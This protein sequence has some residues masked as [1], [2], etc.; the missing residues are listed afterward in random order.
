MEKKR[1]R[2]RIKGFLTQ[3]IEYFQHNST[4]FNIISTEGGFNLNYLKEH[5]YFY[6]FFP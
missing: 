1:P 4:Y 5:I 3:K 2:S 6:T